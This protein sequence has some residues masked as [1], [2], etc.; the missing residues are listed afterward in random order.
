[1]VLHSAA[2]LFQDGHLV[3]GLRDLTDLDLLL[4]HFGGLD[5][6]F[7]A[8]L[9]SRASALGLT[10][11][12][13]YALRYCRRFLATEVPGEVMET[14]GRGRPVRP[15]PA[16]MDFLVARAFLPAREGREAALATAARVLLYARFHWLRLPP[17][18]LA[19]HLAHKGI[20]HWFGSDKS[21]EV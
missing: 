6:G 9:V 8:R 3:G 7:W 21:A 17:W 13:F 19:R 14:A 5:P 10:R 11:P 20:R 4:T 15:V 1:M 16:L 2:H 18:L 12:L